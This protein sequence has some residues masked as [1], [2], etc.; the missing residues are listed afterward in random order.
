MSDEH[1][2][3]LIGRPHF[4]AHVQAEERREG[5]L[6]C[7]IGVRVI[8]FAYDYYKDASLFILQIKIFYS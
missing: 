7:A 5:S 4:T 1:L 2:W 6:I 3:G 8:L